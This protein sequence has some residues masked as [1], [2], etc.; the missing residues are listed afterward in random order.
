V[1]LTLES[2]R[3]TPEPLRLNLEVWKL[4][5]ESRALFRVVETFP[6]VPVAQQRF[7]EAHPGVLVAQQRIRRGSSWSPSGSANDVKRL[8]LEMQS[9][10]FVL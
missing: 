2:Q 1:R 7:E 4:A 8:I 9:F 3:L 10:T 5:K 6:G